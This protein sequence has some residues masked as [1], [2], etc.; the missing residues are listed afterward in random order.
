M[1]K[2]NICLCYRSHPEV[3]ETDRNK[4]VRQ[5]NLSVLWG[6]K[7]QSNHTSWTVV[8][9]YCLSYLNVLRGVKS[10]V[11]VENHG[12]LLL[13]NWYCLYIFHTQFCS[14]DVHLLRVCLKFGVFKCFTECFL[15]LTDFSCSL[16]SVSVTCLY[17]NIL[18]LLLKTKNGYRVK[19][20]SK[21][22]I[23]F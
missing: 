20:I 8:T 4:D 5:D 16:I 15:L 2:I 10:C 19:P 7:R 3:E 21:L 12:L 14:Y 6:I 13:D 11:H 23:I 17:A 9:R 1:T 18:N 22:F